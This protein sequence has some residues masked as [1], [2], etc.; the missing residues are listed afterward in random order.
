LIFLKILH[1]FK[2]TYLNNLE[3]ALTNHEL[4]LP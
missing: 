2:K 1:P 3:K 4:L